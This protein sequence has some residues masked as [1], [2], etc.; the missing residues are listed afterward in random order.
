M[1]DIDVSEATVSG[2]G[3]GSTELE[4]DVSEMENFIISGANRNPSVAPDI[5]LTIEGSSSDTERFVHTPGDAID[6]GTVTVQGLIPGANNDPG[7]LINVQYRFLGNDGSVTIDGN[8]GDVGKDELVVLG[9]LGTDTIDV[10][11]G[12]V[13]GS[14]DID[15]ETPVGMHIDLIGLN[16]EDLI[17]DALEGDDTFNV[18]GAII[19]ETHDALPPG[20]LTLRGARPGRQRRA[21]LQRLGRPGHRRPGSRDDHR[22]LAGC[23]QRDRDDQSRRRRRIAHGGGH[24]CRRR[25]HGDRLRRQFRQD[26][27]GI[28]RAA[29][30]A[31]WLPISWLPRSTTRTPAAR[32]ECPNPVIIDLAAGEDTLLVVGNS[33]SQTFNINGQPGGVC[34]RADRSRR[35]VRFRPT[36]CRLT[37]ATTCRSTVPSPMRT[38]NR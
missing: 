38:T 25:H 3:L 14:V 37:T 31:K 2:S 22:E 23:L 26:R 8:Q 34:G 33:L 19:L 15:V 10:T 9:S 5:L 4:I 28:R 29:R 36:R 7:E 32:V 30:A 12:G 18:D 13:A 24:E 35:T 27:A 11:Y 20:V 17:V 16:V 6:R 21:E 1:S